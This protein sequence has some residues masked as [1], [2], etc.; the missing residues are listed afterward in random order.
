MLGG[1][2]FCQHGVYIYYKLN[3][4]KLDRCRQIQDKFNIKCI[5]LYYSTQKNKKVLKNM[6]NINNLEQNRTIL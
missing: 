5:L 6:Y 4:H 1:V 3:T 2:V